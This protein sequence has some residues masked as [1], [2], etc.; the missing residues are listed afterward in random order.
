MQIANLQM[1]K[2]L[3]LQIEHLQITTFSEG[4]LI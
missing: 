1:T 4:L 2:G 3:V